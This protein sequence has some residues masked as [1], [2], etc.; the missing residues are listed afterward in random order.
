MVASRTRT[1]VPSR[2][3]AHGVLLCALLAASALPHAQAFGA[4]CPYIKNPGEVYGVEDQPLNMQQAWINSTA[5]NEK[6]IA[7]RLWHGQCDLG[8]CGTCDNPTA[9]DGTEKAADNPVTIEY[10]V[11]YGRLFLSEGY[12]SCNPIVDSANFEVIS[13]KQQESFSVTD[14]YGVVN[15]TLQYLMFQGLRFANKMSQLANFGKQPRVTVTVG[16][17]RDGGPPKDGIHYDGPISQSTF[18]VMEEVSETSGSET[19]GSAESI[20]NDPWCEQFF[21]RSRKC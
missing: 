9:E 18:V 21:L 3:L 16:P 15:C 4:F 1:D 5:V 20:A 2:D 12:L 8:V 19:S 14:T 6:G 11:L 17:P 13:D 10:S 7:G